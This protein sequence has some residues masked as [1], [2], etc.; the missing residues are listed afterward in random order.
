MSSRIYIIIALILAIRLIIAYYQ[1]I[2]RSTFTVM[3]YNIA[4]GHKPDGERNESLINSYFKAKKPGIIGLNEVDI[5]TNRSNNTNQLSVVSNNLN[6]NMAFSK[7]LDFQGGYYGNGLLTKYD[8]LQ[9]KQILLY[10][11]QNS[12]QRSLLHTVINVQGVNVNALVTHLE[13]NSKDVRT[14]QLAYIKDYIKKLSGPIIIMGDFNLESSL[15]LEMMTNEFN[16]IYGSSIP[17][18]FPSENSTLDYILYSKNL[19]LKSYVV[20]KKNYSDHYPVSAT[21]SFKELK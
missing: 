20:D 4:S 1:R 2:N 14:K 7:S 16:I 6:Y 11:E 19:D 8:I 17:V 21:F 5:N 10:N 13:Y 3:T 9:Q 18:T 15:E 12:E